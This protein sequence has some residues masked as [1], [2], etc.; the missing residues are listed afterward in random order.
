MA[1]KRKKSGG[2]G[3]NWMDTYGDMVTLLLCFFVLLYS[4][5][6]ISEDKWKAIVM[7]FNP[8]ARP[9]QTEIIAGTENGPSADDDLSGS[10]PMTEEQQK[11]ADQ[12]KIDQA[13]EELYQA[14]KQYAEESE[15]G[16]NISVT[17]GD[18]YVFV[19]FNDA[20][21]FDGDSY[22]LRP[23]GERVLQT[24]SEIMSRAEK[25]ID[26]VVIMGHTAQGNP[27][28]ANTPK[29]D[30]FLSSN[31]ATIVT[32]YIQEHSTLS[33]ARLVSQG[34]GQWRNVADNNTSANRAKN[35][36]V[37]L[38]ITGI[39]LY[40]ELGDSIEQYESV[41]TGEANLQATRPELGSSD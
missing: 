25:Y 16:K 1:I 21:F 31:R 18:G 32:V 34:N 22:V 12:E 14:M 30:R 26:E 13:I 36:R 28:K 8:N 40:N 29:V 9:T 35:R 3:A 33:G 19:S 17:K 2:G 37:E 5:S 27:N 4:I 41:R 10:V 20:V 24:M 23:D 39:D 6:T 11:A 38:M 7:S 15:D